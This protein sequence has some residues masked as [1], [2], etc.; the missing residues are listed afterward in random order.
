M[1]HKRFALFRVGSCKRDSFV[2]VR[3]FYG[4]Q[5]PLIVSCSCRR[6]RVFLHT[7]GFP[8]HSSVFDEEP[9]ISSAFTCENHLINSM[10]QFRYFSCV[11]WGICHMGRAEFVV[12]DVK[13]HNFNDNSVR[14]MRVAVFSKT[15]VTIVQMQTKQC[16]CF[17]DTHFERFLRAT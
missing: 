7:F 17:L 13:T 2:C 16:L 11:R 3:T 5:Q 1:E 14:A 8:R 10:R 4:K 15:E 9:E 12:K 6:L